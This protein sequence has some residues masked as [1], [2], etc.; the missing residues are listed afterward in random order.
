MFATATATRDTD[1]VRGEMNPSCGDTNITVRY[2][3]RVIVLLS[4]KEEAFRN[5][6]SNS[7]SEEASGA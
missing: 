3:T 7:E 2:I 5:S 1:W 4:A 6:N